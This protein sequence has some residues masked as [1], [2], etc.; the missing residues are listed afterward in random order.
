MPGDAAGLP[1][2]I[3]SAA[4]DAGE[5]VLLRVNDRDFGLVPDVETFGSIFEQGF[6]VSWAVHEIAPWENRF[7]GS[8]GS[9]PDAERA[10]RRALTTATQALTNL[11]VARWRPDAANTIAA[12]GAAAPDPTGLPPALGQR[13]IQILSLAARLRDIVALATDDDG[14][15]INLWQADQRGTALREVDYAARHAIAAATFT[16]PTQ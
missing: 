12:L 8:V 2:E 3:S 13:Q 5:C 11:D 10:L 6:L 4:T 7:L 1:P 15:A 9:L 16:H 14:G